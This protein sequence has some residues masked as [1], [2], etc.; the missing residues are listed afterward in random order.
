MK[1]SGNTVLITGGSS[2]IGLELAKK[3]VA[4]NN[5]VIITGRSEK[6]LLAACNEIP[7]IIPEISD[8][9]N[10]SDSRQLTEKYDIN[11]LVN[12]A[13]IQCQYNLADESI[14]NELIIS[15]IN[16][17]FTGQI[18][19]TR[20]FLPMLKLKEKAAIINVTSLLSIVPKESAPVYCATKSAFSSFTKT[21]RWQLSDTSVKVFEL[22]PPLVKTA[23]TKNN[24]KNMINTK[25]LVDAFWKKFE[26]NVY[27]VY[28]QKSKTAYYL[29]RLMPGVVER[30]VRN[31]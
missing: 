10:E 17:N 8:I 15:E 30:R 2:G 23:M 27:T 21:L 25:E 20:A 19:L 9:T 13:G 1:P 12:N 11:I 26:D 14:P 4:E 3:F 24:K 7:E 18:L 28:I 5:T 6:K 29:N 22:V 31:G 16:T